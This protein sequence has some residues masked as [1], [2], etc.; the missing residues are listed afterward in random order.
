[1]DG[2][3]N[4]GR[5]MDAAWKRAIS[6]G[7]KKANAVGGALQRAGAGAVTL[8]AK[9]AVK[10]MPNVTARKTVL[11]GL[12]GATGAGVLGAIAGSSYAGNVAA[13]AATMNQ[14]VLRKH[15][16]FR[17][18]GGNNLIGPNGISKAQK[19][20]GLIIDGKTK[21]PINMNGVSHFMKAGAKAGGAVSAVGGAVIGASSEKYKSKVNKA[22]E[23][24][25]K[26]KL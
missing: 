5:K 3:G 26:R 10:A 24:R 23:K 13:A 12:S 9:G 20:A 22:V 25:A 16:V 18:I 6:E 1:M 21:F 15:G 7:K 4:T 8:A 17:G 2:F 14:R 19:A 11:G